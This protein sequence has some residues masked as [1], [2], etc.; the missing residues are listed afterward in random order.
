MQQE[1]I[2]SQG[3]PTVLFKLHNTRQMPYLYTCYLEFNKLVEVFERNTSLTK[4]C[5]SESGPRVN[6]V[7][8]Y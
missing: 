6:P 2:I 3:K 5:L 8:V 7:K 4:K 1:L